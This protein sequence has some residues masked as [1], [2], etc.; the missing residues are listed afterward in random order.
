LRLRPVSWRTGGLTSG[1]RA[2]GRPRGGY[3]KPEMW[4]PSTV[5]TNNNSLAAPP[6][7]ASTCHGYRWSMSLCA[8]G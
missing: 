8:G 2:L 3:S 4:L 5:R 7:S 6:L 1:P